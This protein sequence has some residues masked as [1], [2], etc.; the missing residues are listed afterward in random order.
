MSIEFT[1]N[2]NYILQYRNQFARI[3]EE[4]TKDKPYDRIARIT[5]LGLPKADR[6]KERQRKY[7][8]KKSKIAAIIISAGYS[9]RM[10]CMKPLLEFNHVAAIE[11]LIQTYRSSGIEDIYVVVG[12]RQ[13]EIRERLKRTDVRIIWNEAYAMGM[14]T[15]IKKGIGELEQTVDAYF[16]QPVDIPLI[17]KTTIEILIHQYSSLEKGVI[18][19]TFCNQKGHPPLIDCQYN[20]RIIKYDG[21]G[22]L[23]KAL[24]EFEAESVCIPVFDRAI[25]MDMDQKD[26][27]EKLVRYDNLHAPDR[28]ECMAILLYYKVPEHVIRH[29]EAVEKTADNLCQQVR[30]YCSYLNK[31]VLLAAALLHDIARK[32]ANHAIA[33]AE[34][35]REIGYPIVGELIAFHMDIEVLEEEPLTEKEI[36]YLSDK[37]VEE[38]RRCR[39]EERFM[40]ALNDNQEN[41]TAVEKINHRWNS[42]KAI[43]SKIE[44]V[45]VSPFCVQTLYSD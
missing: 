40:Q 20:E 23:K 6:S 22:G 25:L 1:N 45:T 4:Q 19:P 2:V 44:R 43:I 31:H 41:L 29:C 36:L 3:K 39:L 7:S 42:A 16:V 26:D 12:Y 28:D 18:Y 11:R 10:N 14:L 5:I 21:A 9:S 30:P 32:E 33:G 15:S 17:K 27:Y 13:E 37:L 38:D 8:V 35:L 34:L 24:K